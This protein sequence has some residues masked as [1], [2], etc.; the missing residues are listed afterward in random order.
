MPILQRAVAHAT[1]VFNIEIA[2]GIRPPAQSR[3]RLTSWLLRSTSDPQDA[4]F[5]ALASTFVNR[6]GVSHPIGTAV[7]AKPDHSSAC[8]GSCGPAQML[9]GGT[10]TRAVRA[11]A[12]ADGASLAIQLTPTVDAGSDRPELDATR[13]PRS[14]GDGDTEHECPAS[15]STDDATETSAAMLLSDEAVAVAQTASLLQ[16]IGP[17]QDTVFISS[18]VGLKSQ[19]EL[20]GEKSASDRIPTGGWDGLLS[21]IWQTIVD[22]KISMG[23]WAKSRRPELSGTLRIVVRL[24]GDRSI[25]NMTKDQASELKRRYFTLPSDHKNL[26]FDK[27]RKV[28]RTYDEMMAH[29]AEIEASQGHKLDRVSPKTWNKQRSTLSAAIQWLKANR[30]AAKNL[31]DPFSGLHTK[32]KK[33]QTSARLERDMA[34]TPSLEALFRTPCWTGRAN[35]YHLTKS[36]DIII[37]D[38]LYWAPL[39][40]VCLGMRREEVCQLRVRHFRPK[41]SYIGVDLFAED[42]IVKTDDG[43]SRRW[44]PL[45]KAMLELGVKE[46]LLDGRNSDGLL[47]PELSNENAHGTFGDSYGKRFLYYVQHVSPDFRALAEERCAQRGLVGTE[48]LKGIEEQEANLL[49]DFRTKT[50]NHAIRHWFKTVLENADCKTIF[51]EELMGHSNSYQK[52]EGG[53]YMKEVF[54]ENL[55]KTVDMVPLPFDPHH[56]RQ[57]AERS[58]KDRGR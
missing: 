58:E 28:E 52:S 40:E 33:S 34:T 3:S 9:A 13:I 55:K 41:S 22:D 44:I 31:T 16:T 12:Q 26:W 37:R 54:I 5:D 35:A 20:P 19:T 48:R 50:N 32:R 47:F 11:S 36:G 14:P 46:S 29:V 49:K 10:T 53:R 8:A 1:A 6:P 57:L 56:L 7:D 38:S 42:L 21:T 30:D 24:H 51:V 25:L 2:N 18:E 39:F 23:E 45:S 15:A 17:S 43:A 27:K 4:I